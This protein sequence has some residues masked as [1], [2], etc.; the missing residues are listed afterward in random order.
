MKRRI[1]A[2]GGGSVRGEFPS[3]MQIDSEAVSLAKET[4]MCMRRTANVLFIPT[5]SSDD[6]SY[7][8]AVYVL[9]RR[10]LRCRYDDLLLLE[11][12]NSL[13]EIQEKL[14]WA[15]IIYVGGGNTR[16]MMAEWKHQG[17]VPLLQNAME[18]GKVLIGLSAGSICWFEA[19]LSDSNKFDGDPNWRP[20]WVKGLGYIPLFHSPHHDSE[21]WRPA[22]LNRLQ[23]E[24][25]LTKNVLSI[26][27]DCAIQ[28]EGDKY[29]IIY[30]GLFEKY[31]YLYTTSGE[32]RRLRPH[33]DFRSIS[34]LT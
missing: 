17:L 25:E 2:I 23:R 9:Y 5:A 34:L 3:T 18:Q 21:R 16:D 24:G 29:R 14:N 27:D 1:I 22:E 10:Y 13:V 8:S 31:A 6:E 20:M 7:C 33:A 4:L 11:E 15:D 28:I 19:G 32:K 30:S 12:N 26:E